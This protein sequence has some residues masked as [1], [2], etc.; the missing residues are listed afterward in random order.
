MQKT[1]LVV[2]DD[3]QLRNSLKKILA[4]NKYKVAEASDGAE[5]LEAV[6]KYF[7]DL[8]LLDFGLPKVSGETVCVKIK[9]DHPEIIIIALTEKTRDSDVVHG[10]QIGADDY[11]GKPFNVE[12]LVARIEAR[13][14]TT[15]N[16][17]SGPKTEEVRSGKDR[18]IFRESI[19]LLVFRL[20]LIEVFFG[21]LF[22]LFNILAS[23]ID[24]YLTTFNLFTL[25]FTILA[26]ALLINVSLVIFIALKWISEFTEVSKEGVTKHTG[27][28]NKKEQ[29]F[30]CSF[31]EAAK[32]EQSFIGLIFKYG[33]VELYD[34]ALK[35]KVYLLNISNPKK[36]SERI[37]K[38]VA[39][40][41]D[42]PIPFI[43]RQ[44]NKT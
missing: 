34:P 33:T 44:D 1:I 43:A 36:Q 23:F 24:S 16:E 22:F 35:E 6:E 27:I 4:D 5:A 9:K 17:S 2:E 11:I 37:Q 40:Q 32:V 19:I 31:V 41:N 3:D 15:A 26:V 20:I 29:K 25:N 12:E 10:L 42:Q 21:L 18:I 13:F 30:A 14:K 7:P 39:K 8:I 28:L 38:I